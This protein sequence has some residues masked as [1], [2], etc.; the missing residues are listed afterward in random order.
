MADPRRKFRTESGAATS[1][2][3]PCQ[4]CILSFVDWRAHNMA[5]SFYENGVWSNGQRWEVRC[6]VLKFTSGFKSSSWYQLT[7]EPCR[8]IIRSTDTK[9]GSS[10]TEK[11]WKNRLSKP[12]L[13]SSGCS[14]KEKSFPSSILLTGKETSPKNGIT[15]EKCETSLLF[16][17]GGELCYSQKKGKKVYGLILLRWDKG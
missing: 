5:R 9:R 17:G 12:V 4:S 11:D 3:L 14:K 15:H 2:N 16:Y 10:E 7:R 8:A 1:L 13:D 6:Q